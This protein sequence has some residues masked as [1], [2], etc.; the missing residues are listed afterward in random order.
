M[1]HIQR[2]RG[3]PPNKRGKKRAVLNI[4]KKYESPERKAQMKVR[5][6]YEKKQKQQ[7]NENEKN[8]KI[9]KNQQKQ[10]QLLTNDNNHLEIEN[11]SIFFFALFLCVFI[12]FI[13][14]IFA[15]VQAS[16][17]IKKNSN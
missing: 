11:Q 9:I 13:L 2:G 10:I 17:N 12:S 8:K 1:S 15:H 5:K 3:R 7:T 6:K 4:T 14:R 16:K